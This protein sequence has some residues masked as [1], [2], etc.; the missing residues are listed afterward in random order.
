MGAISSVFMGERAFGNETGSVM[1]ACGAGAAGG[2]SRDDVAGVCPLFE[3][4]CLILGWYLIRTVYG[5]VTYLFLDS[6]SSLA[7]SVIPISASSSSS[8][9]RFSPAIWRT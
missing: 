9:F 6:D 2:T 3:V 7:A 4:R 8:L 1:M 5:I